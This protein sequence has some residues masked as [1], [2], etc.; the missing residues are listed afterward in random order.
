MEAWL[1]SQG[2][3]RIVSGSQKRP[4][5]KS[6]S[7]SED[8]TTVESATASAAAAAQAELLQA[9]TLELQDAWNAKSDKAA[10]WIWLMLDKDQKTLVDGCKDDPCAMWTTLEST[11]RQKKAG[12]CFNAYDDLFSI[13]K[14]DDE[15]LQPK[16]FDLKALDKEL[17]SMVLICALP[18]EYSHFVSSLLLLMDKLDKDTVQ[19]AFLTEEIQRRRCAADAVSIAAMAAASAPLQCEFCSCPGHAQSTCR[20]FARAQETAR[21]QAASGGSWKRQG[22]KKAQ[23]AP[24]T[25]PAAEF[26]G[27]ASAISDLPDPSSLIQPHADFRWNAD[28]GCTS[29][30]TTHR[31]QMRNYRLYHVLVELAD[32]NVI[33]LA[34]IGSVVID[35]VI[36]GKSV[37]SVELARVLHVPQ[38][39]SNLLSCLFLTQCCGFEFHVDSVFMHSVTLFRAR[40]TP[41]NTVYIA[42]TTLPASEAAC[43]IT[44]R[45]LDLQLWHE[46]LWHHNSADIQKLISHGLATGITLS[47]SAKQCLWCMAYVFIQKDK[48]KKVKSH[49][50]K[51]IFVGYPPDYHAWTFYN[52]VTKH[53]IISECTEFDDHMFPGLSVKQTTPNAQLQLLV[54]PASQPAPS[55]PIL[56]PFTPDNPDAS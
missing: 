27:N 52:P 23:E 42:E 36:G 7:P 50:Q 24:A 43:A 26:A 21:K 55:N 49:Y 22:A 3:W 19:Q 2:L 15:S 16:D 5:L 37:R 30:M 11:Y 45:P 9:K 41:N 48:H 44:T 20:T 1:K 4:E 17:T 38:L 54:T 56:S 32:G 34:G 33:Y 40:I 31:H 25:V 13:R 18:D 8:T 46:C 39:R 10:G 47:S 12:S 51:C 35:P 28:T 14:S 6:P 29:T 53:F